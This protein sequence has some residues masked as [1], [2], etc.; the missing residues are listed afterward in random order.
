M[1]SA[2]AE[3]AAEV[4][5][6]LA[7]PRPRMPPRMPSLARTRAVT[8]CPSGSPT[9][10]AAGAH[11]CSESGPRG[12]GQGRAAAA[13]GRAGPVRGHGRSW[14]AGAR[15]GRRSAGAGAAQLHRSRQPDHEDQG[16]L[17]P[18][19][20]RPARRRQRPSDHRRPAP[21]TNGRDQAGLV[22]LLEPPRP[23]SAGSPASSRPM[24]ATSARPTSKRGGARH[25]GHRRPAGAST[26]TPLRV[27]SARSG[28]A[29]RM[30]AMAARTQARRP[31]LA[32]SPAQ[33]DRRAGLRP[34]QARP[35][36]PPVPLAR[37]R[38]GPGRVG[39][40]LH[41]PQPDQ[42]GQ[43]PTCLSPRSPEPRPSR[44][45]HHDRQRV[46]RANATQPFHYSDRL[47]GRPSFRSPCTYDICRRI[48]KW[49]QAPTVRRLRHYGLTSVASRG[50][51]PRPALS[52]ECR[53]VLCV[54]VPA[55]EGGNSR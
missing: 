36:L 54:V 18:G 47:L 10:G 5:G 14:P 28:R 15:P 22:P 40:D 31:T 39:A 13:A 50:S 52:R 33:A 30:A 7:R 45:A 8:S 20:Q 48:R 21:T 53:Q 35:R 9:R 41:R 38:Q 25:P 46:T 49:Y 55:A 24:P 42:T 19:L 51:Q 37:P 16:W 12:R 34:D 2:E 4:K 27:V 32:L 29:S 44:H 26:A 23:R 1:Q 43:H 6:W 11:P 17:H 3:L